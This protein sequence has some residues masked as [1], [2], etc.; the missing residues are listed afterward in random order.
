MK[1]RTT[2]VLLLCIVV[3]SALADWENGDPY[4]MHYPQLPDPN[5]WDVRVEGQTVA[6]DWQCAGSGPV[7]GI[8]FWVSWHEDGGNPV[9]ILNVHLSIHADIPDPDGPGPLY[10][11]P[12]E[13][14]W[15]R[16]FGSQDIAYLLGGSGDQGWYDPVGDFA[17]T[18]DHSLYW[19]INVD[20]ISDPFVQTKG[21]IYW[22]DLQMATQSSQPVGWKT[23]ISEH[24][25]DDSVFM[26]AEGGW[27]ELRD[28][29]E[30]TVSLDQAFVIV[31]EPAS[32][33]FGLGFMA[34]FLIWQRLFRKGSSE[35]CD[36]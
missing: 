7:S 24:W 30:P 35:D 25:N 8:H 26:M 9:D 17:L 16:D 36:I 20:N 5:G 12:G 11:M 34:V 2:I 32:V 29:L 6:D 3:A 33:A 22:L 10:S 14:L 4:K 15:E 1:A 23:S 21:N 31:P 19:Q 28:P 13:L 27:G 18:N